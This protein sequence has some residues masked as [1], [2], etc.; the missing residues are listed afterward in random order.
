MLNKNWDAKKAS[1]RQNGGPA[2]MPRA[3]KH[4]SAL[5][6]ASFWSSKSKKKKKKIV[7]RRAKVKACGK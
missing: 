3:Q 6:F 5:S 1:A 2:Q 7:K 4:R